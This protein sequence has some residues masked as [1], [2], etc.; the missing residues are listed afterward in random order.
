MGKKVYRFSFANFYSPCMEDDKKSTF[1][2]SMGFHTLFIPL[3][4]NLKPLNDWE[5]PS[6]FVTVSSK[7]RIVTSIF[8][9]SVK[10]CKAVYC[11]WILSQLRLVMYGRF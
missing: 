6:A 1:N 3:D 8:H 10:Q 7:F 5:H 9:R 4:A 11:Y 2:L